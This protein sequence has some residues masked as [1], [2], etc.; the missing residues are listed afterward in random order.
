LAL[1]VLGILD[2]V[3]RLSAESRRGCYQHSVVGHV[4]P[5]LLFLKYTTRA[6]MMRRRSRTEMDATMGE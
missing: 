6:T 3:G 2:M 4:L 5:F 1:A